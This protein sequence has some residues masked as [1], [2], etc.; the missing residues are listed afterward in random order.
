M[1]GQLWKVAILAALAG[2]ARA[3]TFTLLQSFDSPSAGGPTTTPGALRA[4]DVN[5]DG[6][7]DIFFCAAASG[8]NPGAVGVIETGPSGT[9]VQSSLYTSGTNPVS[10]AP[11]F[12]LGTPRVVAG[13]GGNPRFFQRTS[14]TWQGWT[15]NDIPISG[16]GPVVAG[17]FGPAG[18]AVTVAGIRPYTATSVLLTSR[19]NPAGGCSGFPGSD[20]WQQAPFSTGTLIAAPLADAGYVSPDLVAFSPESGAAEVYRVDG[21]VNG[22][23][24]NTGTDCPVSPGGLVVVSVASILNLPQPVAAAAGDFDGDGDNDLAFL[25]RGDQTLRVFLNNGQGSFTAGPT[26]SVPPGAVALSSGL[27]SDDGLADLVVACASP[28]GNQLVVYGT[29]GPASFRVAATIAT[30]GDPTSVV[31]GRFTSDTRPDIA[32][33]TASDRK[34]TIYQNNSFSLCAQ[35]RTWTQ[36]VTAPTATPSGRYLSASA[37]DSLRALVFMFGGDRGDGFRYGDLWRWDGFA[38]SAAPSTNPPSARRGPALI[39]DSDRDRVVLFGG[40]SASGPTSEHWELNPQ[41]GAWTDRTGS[42]SVRPP[43]RWAHAMVY[44][45]SRHRA[46]LYGGVNA[47]GSSRDDTWLFDGTAWAQGPAAPPGLGARNSAGMVYD[48]LRR[49][50]ILFGGGSGANPISSDTWVFDGTSWSQLQTAGGPPAPR[51]GP[52]MAYDPVAARVVLMGGVGGSPLVPLG[53]SWELSGIQWLPVGADHPGARSP[54][55]MAYHA[56]RSQTVL[57]SGYAPGFPA[58]TWAFSGPQIRTQPASLV[59]APGQT[60]TFTVEATDPALVLSYHWHHGT[61]PVGT[62]SPVLTI[63][64]ISAPDSGPYTVDVQFPCGTDVSR[65]ATL[66]VQSCY[67]NCDGSTAAPVLNVQ[68]FGCFLVRFAQGDP[69]AN[70]DGSTTPPVLNVQ[71]FTCFL[72]RFAQGCP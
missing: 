59:L 37:Y 55:M 52:G 61:T 16:A 46:V 66:T 20:S 39:Y 30:T 6:R 28:A 72:Q 12:L 27:L 64:N 13:T 47:D 51:F 50:T 2:T 44:D 1:N 68:D 34:V 11:F 9:F 25:C 8:P 24:C 56:G 42:L 63:P 67:P 17:S 62:N 10:V 33:S 53:D 58:E 65:P 54:S 43:A 60:A 48:S 57:F 40:D 3:Q 22:L 35:A 5:G 71:D 49:Q 23:C 70:C 38:W 4:L 36:R 19:T 14:G 15:L 41:T 32:V 7:E 45:S 31:V 29:E 18:S 21:V 69:Y 26:L